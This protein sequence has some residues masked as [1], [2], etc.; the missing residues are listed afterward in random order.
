M[1]HW[2]LGSMNDGLFIID[3]PP[4]PSTDDINPNVGP[5]VVLNVTNLPQEKA[6]AIVAAHNAEVEKYG[7]TYDCGE[8]GKEIVVDTTR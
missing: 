3:R 4:R 5:D 8:C 7:K 2:Y 6:E 1:K